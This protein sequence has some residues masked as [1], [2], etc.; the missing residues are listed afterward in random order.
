MNNLMCNHGLIMFCAGVELVGTTALNSHL[1]THST[2]C[3]VMDPMSRRYQYNMNAA[4]A[5]LYTPVLLGLLVSNKPQSKNV[6]PG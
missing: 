6:D 3:P 1:I 2:Q 5:E 4:L